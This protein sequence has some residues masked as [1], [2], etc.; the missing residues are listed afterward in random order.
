MAAA[1]SAIVGSPPTAAAPEQTER[2]TDRIIARTQDLFP[3]MPHRLCSLPS[4]GE[5]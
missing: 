4:G 3:E 2:M 5:I 1:P